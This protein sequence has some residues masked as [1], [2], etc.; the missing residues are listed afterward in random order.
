[1]ITLTEQRLTLASGR[2]QTVHRGGDGPPLLWLHSL[3][4]FEADDP[5]LADLATRYTVLAPAAPGMT[6]LAELDD[7]DDVHDLALHYDDLL[8]AA[9]LDRV[10]VV[11]HSFGAM[12]GAE[13]AAHSPRRVSRLALLSPVGLWS[14]DEP[15]TDVFAVPYTDVAEVLFADPGRANLRAQET[16]T[17][18]RDI[19]AVVALA[20][21]MTTVAKFLWP[22][23]DRGLAKRLYR[24]AAPSLVV[25]GEKDAFVPPAYG[26]RFAG[27]LPQG[28]AEV[29]SDAGHMIQREQPEDVAGLLRAFLG[30]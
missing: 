5:V 20:Q 10:D 3:Y 2:T 12:I 7:I 16:E 30:A 4:G 18:E 19:E 6:D 9:G 27:L 24:I 15:V 21:A 23:P 14:D 29:V 8:D 25:F 1:M 11:G 26:E 17:G 22:V 13:L 28:R